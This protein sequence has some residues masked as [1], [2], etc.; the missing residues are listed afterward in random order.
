MSQKGPFHFFDI[1]QQRM[2][3]KSQMFSFTFLALR[4]F[5][6]LIFRLILSFLNR[7]PLLIFFQY[8]PQFGGLCSITLC[9]VQ[10]FDVI[11]KPFCVFISVIAGLLLK[12]E[13]VFF[14]SKILPMILNNSDFFNMPDPENLC[15]ESLLRL[16]KF[17]P[18]CSTRDNF[19]SSV[20]QYL[21]TQCINKTGTSKVGAISKAQKAQ[22]F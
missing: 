19:S 3:K 2:L 10:F 13:D 14:F 4:L 11:S 20:A 6:I 1:L 9:Y 5:K 22:S 16:D 8:Y 15:R 7:Y 21:S 17:V 18:R 12:S